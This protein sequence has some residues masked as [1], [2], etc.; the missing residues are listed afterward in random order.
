MGA[1]RVAF[2]EDREHFHAAV[3]FEIGATRHGITLP[4]PDPNADVY[5]W[6]PARKFRR[7]AE[8]QRAA[9]LQDVKAS[10]RAFA[11]YVK[12]LRIA[13]EA[14]ILAVREALLPYAVLANG[15]TVAEYT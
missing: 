4:L 12:A 5:K 14:R 11:E 2:F 13:Q 6:T 3:A 15:Q 10:W 8:E 7:D 1:Q 9:W